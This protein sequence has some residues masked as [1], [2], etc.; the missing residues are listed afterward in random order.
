MDTLA[1]CSLR[2]RDSLVIMTSNS[3]S[4]SFSIFQ[5]GN[6]K[7]GIY[8]IQNLHTQTFLDIQDS[9]RSVC[10]RPATHIGEGRGLPLGAGYS[11]Q[12]VEPGKP[13]QFCVHSGVVRAD[14]HPSLGV[15]PY[16]MAWR[17]EV[18]ED[19]QYRGFEY[20]RFF[21][22]T[23]DIVWDLAGGNKEDGAEVILYPNNPPAPSLTWKLIPMKVENT[24]PPSQLLSE[25]LGSGSPPTYD[26]YVAEPE[27]PTHT[28]HIEYRREE[29]GTIVNEVTVVTTNSTVTT[30]K[31][32][33]VE[34]A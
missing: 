8:K 15:I 33:R 6:L 34:D 19:E 3:T 14:G 10:C 16:P 23:K 24:I 7:P 20:V 21:W 5:G 4:D 9:S 28:Q 22:G 30:R 26:G 12:R 32:Y 1:S 31:R 25:I 29:F 18:A 2:Y 11:V 27:S 13:A 17:L